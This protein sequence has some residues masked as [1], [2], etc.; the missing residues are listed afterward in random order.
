MTYCPLQ[1]LVSFGLLAR[2]CSRYSHNLCTFPRAMGTS[3]T[4]P[5]ACMRPRSRKS[6]TIAA[7]SRSSWTGKQRAQEW[8]ILRVFHFAL[9][10]VSC[11]W[12]TKWTCGATK[13][14]RWTGWHIIFS[15]SNCLNRFWSARHLFWAIFDLFHE[16]WK[17]LW[18]GQL[19]RATTLAN[20]RWTRPGTHF[21]DLSRP[22]RNIFLDTFCLIRKRSCSWP[23]P[24]CPT[25][26]FYPGE[27]DL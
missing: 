1:L 6:W 14:G 21:S 13:I 20:T 4:W 27:I 26:I 8:I 17:I 19:T 15:S 2:C 18:P 5:T 12:R 11:A 23:V 22:D 16:R 9:D 7:A 24:P 3:T 10:L 25:S